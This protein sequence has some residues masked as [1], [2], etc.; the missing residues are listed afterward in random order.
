MDIWHVVYPYWEIGTNVGKLLNAGSH[1]M[2][3][4]QSCILVDGIMTDTPHC[5]TRC[6]Y[7][8]PQEC[9]TIT[10]VAQESCVLLWCTNATVMSA[11][12]H[13]F[14]HH[15]DRRYWDLHFNTATIIT[16]CL[17][18]SNSYTLTYPTNTSCYSL[19]TTMLLLHYLGMK[20]I[21]C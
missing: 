17:S 18:H 14:I 13:C 21:V 6:L 2:I 12:F 11:D 15:Q 16:S 1:A 8:V 5:E 20:Y 4:F 10:S 3:P 7:H 19:C 9:T